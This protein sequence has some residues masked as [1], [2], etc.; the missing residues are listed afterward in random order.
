MPQ[1]RKSQNSNKSAVVNLRGSFN[2]P[3][4]TRSAGAPVY[5]PLNELS[6][7]SLPDSSAVASE[8][9]P[10]H[11]EPQEKPT[12]EYDYV[13]PS[14]EE[15]DWGAGDSIPAMSTQTQPSPII[16]EKEPGN[17]EVDAD[18]WRGR[19][20]TRPPARERTAIRFPE[21][22]AEPARPAQQRPNS[23]TPW[24]T[25]QDN[26]FHRTPTHEPQ[27]VPAHE[28]ARTPMRQPARPPAS[29]PAPQLVHQPA[30]VAVNEVSV[31]PPSAS[32]KAPSKVPTNPPAEAPLSAFRKPRPHT[33][34]DWSSSASP[35]SILTLASP[36]IE[37]LKPHA[38][39]RPAPREDRVHQLDASHANIDPGAGE[40]LALF[41]SNPALAFTEQRSRKLPKRG[42][43]IVFST[44][45]EQPA[46]VFPTNFLFELKKSTEP[47]STH[48]KP[49][50]PGE[51]RPS[52]PSTPRPRSRT[53]LPTWRKG[54]RVPRTPG[55]RTPHEQVAARK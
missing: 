29:Q 4:D 8:K 31:A 18:P 43:R 36:R 5:T 54:G 55:R 26:T 2:N 38:P 51:R 20:K 47:S 39:P 21:R 44:R 13:F 42:I 10:G 37:D 16:V 24:N 53:G 34:S 52:G 6:I 14:D 7:P 50:Q 49:C 48:W 27:R 15:S 46:P 12:K 41:R 40:R 22:S 11:H 45:Q 3:A 30:R 28:L 9:P 32:P 1:K 17:T 35:K 23:T 33:N 25:R 19:R